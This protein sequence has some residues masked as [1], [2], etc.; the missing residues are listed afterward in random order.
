MADRCGRGILKQRRFAARAARRRPMG[1][2]AQMLQRGGADCTRSREAVDQRSGHR[3]TPR[4]G[5]VSR[6]GSWYDALPNN[7]RHLGAC[8][9]SGTGA[10]GGGRQENGDPCFV[11]SSQMGRW[12]VGDRHLKQQGQDGVAS[13]LGS[14][15]FRVFSDRTDWNR[16]NSSRFLDRRGCCRKGPALARFGQPMREYS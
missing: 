6:Q 9:A 14:S 16:T 15:G 7:N 8:V 11:S 2:D 5:S 10:N 4:P 1:P 13:A 12:G 3:L